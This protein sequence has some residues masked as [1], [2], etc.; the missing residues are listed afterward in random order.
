MVL[1]IMWI[2]PGMIL[3]GAMAFGG[4]HLWI[5]RRREA[6]NPDL[7]GSRIRPEFYDDEK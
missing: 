3:L 2:V 4:I 6:K 7:Y 5:K 1:G